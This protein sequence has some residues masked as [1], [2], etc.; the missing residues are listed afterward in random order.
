MI[1][2]QG[3]GPLDDRTKRAD[4]HEVPEESTFLGP[5]APRP[6][7]SD[8]CSDVVVD[9]IEKLEKCTTLVRKLLQCGGKW[10]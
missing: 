4:R 10:N 2:A 1:G 6:Y 7:V 9:G 5:K 3:L 8:N